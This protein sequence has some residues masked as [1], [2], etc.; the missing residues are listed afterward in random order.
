MKTMFLK[1]AGVPCR[2]GQGW[3][4]AALMFA[5]TARSAS[6]AT[7]LVRLVNFQFQPQFLTNHPGD[8]VLW[9][10]TTTTFHN[11]V[12][13]NNVWRAPALFSSPG[14]FPV[15]FTNAGTYG[16]YCSPHLSF[17]MTGIIY[18]QAPDRPPV[19]A[20]TNPVSG[21]TLAAPATTTLRASASDPDGSV[22][23]V[24][25]FSGTTA[26]GTVATRPYSLVVSNLAAGTYRFTAKAVD[27]AGLSSTSAVVTVSVVTPGPIRFDNNLALLNGQL[28]LRVTLTHG[29]SYEIDYTSTFSDWLF[30]T[31]FVATNSVMSFSAPITGSEQRFFRARRLSN[32]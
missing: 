3:L 27:N 23:R 13:S 1:P 15:T 31:N 21:V 25:F 19:V 4:C 5:L 29:L 28:L 22:S 8:T 20:L 14:T 30:F 10:N 18:V 12:S 2:G 24:Q 9:T 7:N 6:A 32:P 17:G 11:V 26:L 16:Y